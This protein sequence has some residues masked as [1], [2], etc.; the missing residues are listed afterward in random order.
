MQACVLQPAS[1]PRLQHRAAASCT[2]VPVRSP[3]S[4]GEWDL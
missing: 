3:G 4:R 2:N 1:Q